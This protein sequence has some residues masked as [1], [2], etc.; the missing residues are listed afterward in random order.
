MKCFATSLACAA[1][2]GACAAGAPPAPDKVQPPTTKNDSQETF[3]VSRPVA[4]GEPGFAQAK[5]DALRE[6]DHYCASLNKGLKV[7]DTSEERPAP[8]KDKDKAPKYE[9]RFNCVAIAEP[10]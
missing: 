4:P 8:G 6:A 1:L 3:V 10:E 9:V 5:A 7:Q 2:L